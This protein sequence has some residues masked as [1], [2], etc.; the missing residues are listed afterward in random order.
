MSVWR[1]VTVENVFHA[2][3][4]GDR[5]DALLVTR[6]RRGDKKALEA[7]IAKHQQ[8]IYNLALRMAGS[9]DD[10]QDVTQE[11]LIKIVTRLGSFEGRS[12][13]RTW[14]YRIVVNHVLTMK[15]KPW[16]RYFFSFERHAQLIER[17]GRP[18]TSPAGGGAVD[19][20]LLLQETRTGCMTGMLLCLDRRERIS[21]IL[22]VFFDADSTLGG[23]LLGTSPENYRQVLS[24]AR[25][26]LANFM[27]DNCGMMNESNTCRCESRIQGARRAGLID[28]QK[29][30]FNLPF[31][32]KV[33]DFVEEEAPFVEEAV[34]MKLQGLLRDLP[35]Y[36]SPDFQ[37]VV[38]LM[39]RRG[40][41][42]KIV[43]FPRE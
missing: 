36:A 23:A 3:Y 32:N 43:R 4:A 22:S 28:P 11:I 31:L 39:V 6:A 37:R 10:S 26:R 33:R 42:G 27:N 35:L 19:E 24:R 34:Q 29:P 38:S 30:R 5:D 13:F 8:W 18:G 9:P 20:R 14:L 25:R 40:K 16:E 17:L 12:S 2:K 7:L 15:R 1:S 21:L 41:I